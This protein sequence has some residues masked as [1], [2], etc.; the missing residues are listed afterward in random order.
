M[1]EGRAVALPRHPEDLPDARLILA[2][3]H[4]ALLLVVLRLTRV[5]QVHRGLRQSRWEVV[6]TPADDRVS[7]PSRRPS[8]NAG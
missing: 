4:E 6:G 8:C 7:I 3:L 5:V 2:E 1:H